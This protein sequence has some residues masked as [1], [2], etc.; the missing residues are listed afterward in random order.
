MYLAFLIINCRQPCT[1]Y[2]WA[3]ATLTRSRLGVLTSICLTGCTKKIEVC[4]FLVDIH[5][6]AG[7]IK[8]T[9]SRLTRHALSQAWTIYEPTYSPG[10]SFTNKGFLCRVL[11]CQLRF[12]DA[13]IS[14]VTALMIPDFPPG[15]IIY[16]GIYITAPWAYDY[17]TH[18]VE[19]PRLRHFFCSAFD[20]RWFSSNIPATLS[21]C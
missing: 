10:A 13:L 5:V 21:S 8:R 3:L 12:N 17:S 14:T 20:L 15:A 2:R 1:H 9:T 11:Q 6:S 16:L 19:L 18:L 4:A 7:D